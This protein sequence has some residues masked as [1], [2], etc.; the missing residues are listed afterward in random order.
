MHIANPGPGEHAGF[1]KLVNAEIRP[2]HGT[3][4]AWDDFPLILD[5]ANSGWTLVARTAEGAVVAGLAAL[6]REYTTNCGR[7]SVAGL[8]SVVTHPDHRGQ[9]LSR[10]LQ[11]EMVA[12]L[13]RQKVPL[14]VLWT[15]KPEIYA[16]RG[17][18]TAGWEHHV[19]LDG[20]DLPPDTRAR[21]YVDSDA[22][23]VA[24]LY[25]AHRW[26]TVRRPG[27]DARL[28]G[29]PGTRG[30]VAVDAADAVTAACFCGKGADFPG[31]VTEWSGALDRVVGLLGVVVERGWADHL[32]APP[33]SEAL[34]DALAS[35]GASWFANP[36]GQWCV[37]DP[38]GLAKAARAAGVAPPADANAADAAAWLGRVDSEGLPQP[39]PLH[40]AVWGF[41]SV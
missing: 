1:R 26:R 10:A 11:D 5:P 15:D 30:L 40:L 8:G 18:T 19:V 23:A 37:L 13:R 31:Y 6:I 7:I 17:F 12:R 39:G 21:A 20:A 36:S 3:T 32:L 9:G 27:D 2:D 16:G 35:R 38:A 33:G 28:Y 24:A 22:D 34:V 29:M 4:S 41:D 14:A 25:A